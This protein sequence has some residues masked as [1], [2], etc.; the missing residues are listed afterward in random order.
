[1]RYNNNGGGNNNVSRF[2]GYFQSKG[3]N[4]YNQ[5]SG[6]GPGSGDFGQGQFKISDFSRNNSERSSSGMLNID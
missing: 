4:N 1:M 2:A 5:R 6:D 3:H